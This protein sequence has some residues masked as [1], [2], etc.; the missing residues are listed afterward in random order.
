VEEVLAASFAGVRKRIEPLRAGALGSDVR[1]FGSATTRRGVY[2]HLDNHVAEHL[3]QL[4][5]YAR[6]CGIAPPWTER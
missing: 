5:A 2:I 3:G 6:V 4:I 1:Y